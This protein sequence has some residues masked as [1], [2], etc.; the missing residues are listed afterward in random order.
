[1]PRRASRT[2]IAADVPRDTSIPI[3]SGAVLLTDDPDGVTTV[4][5]NGVPSSTMRVE[6]E[7]LDF[8][9]MRHFAAAIAAW[10]RPERMLA[11]HVG[12]GVCTMARH[13]AHAYPDS[14]HIA[15]DVDSTL[16]ELARQWWDLPR[17]PQL[18]VRSQDGLDA[19]ATRHEHSLDL[20]LRDAF[21]GD[22]TPAPLAGREWWMHARRAV[23]PGGLVVANVKSAP[24]L[25]THRP[26]AAAARAAFRD[27]LAIGEP[28]VLKGKRRGNVV[29]VASDGIDTDAL[30]RY[31]ASAPLPTGVDFGWPR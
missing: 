19:V 29:L 20:L 16:P 27:V 25:A 10:E 6:P 14:R 12:A 24:D 3:A 4:W 13:L 8:E 23:R 22:S 31:A 28:A 26:D 7:V 9:Y 2:A 11:L 5:V 18:R 21:A 17:S 1:M 15:V 30:R